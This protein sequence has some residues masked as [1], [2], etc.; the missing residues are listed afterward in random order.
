MSASWADPSRFV[1]HL[2]VEES[3]LDLPYTQEII[4]RS[5]LPFSVVCDREDPVG[6]SGQYPGNLT[7]GKQHLL[8]SRNRGQF[9]K[10]CP[11]TPEY[12]CCEYQVLN[13]G[14]NCPMDC[15]YCILQAYLNQPWLSF[16]VNVEDLFSELDQAFSAEP[17]RFFRIG[18][19]EFTDSMAL[20]R[21]T[22]LSVKLVNYMANQSNGILELKSKSAV[23]D[24]LHG[25]DHR[26]RTV[27]AW[28][29]NATSIMRHEELRSASLD[30]RLTA[31]RQC[32]DWGYKLAFHFDPIIDHPGWREGYKETID[33]LFDMVPADQIAWIS[34]GGLRY[35]PALKSIGT[36][37]FPGSTIFYQ[38]F[39]EGLD[40]KPRYF[41]QRR[42]EL[43]Q[44]IHELLKKRTHDRTCI[45]F[46]MESDEVW[47]SVMGFIPEERGGIP[48]LLDASVQGG[49]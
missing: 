14:M 1:R 3:C 39:V 31:A 49:W 44:H 35:L 27:M 16:F 7:E 9:F 6:I 28:S 5:K 33:R 43:Y 17:D 47:Q 32:A 22:G 20:D 37:R 2:H 41:R 26:G 10:P 48:A 11:G 36:S 29:L 30:E 18:T 4:S 45:Y 8:L 15:V 21:L 40:N 46:C 34:L 25:L 13:I 38:E 19:G 42:V 24:N 12:R 23:I